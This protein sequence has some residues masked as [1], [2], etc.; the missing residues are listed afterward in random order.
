MEEE[1]VNRFIAVA[2]NFHQISRLHNCRRT[3]RITRQGLL[4]HCGLDEALDPP[5]YGDET[6]V[7]EFELLHD[8]LANS[9]FVYCFGCLEAAMI[10]ATK[11]LDLHFDPEV[12]ITE[13]AFTRHQGLT[14]VRKFLARNFKLEHVKDDQIGSWISDLSNIRNLLVHACGKV[15][16]TNLKHRAK[17][18]N[19]VDRAKRLELCKISIDEEV[20]VTED[21]LN[22]LFQF[23][24]G[25]LSEIC[26]IQVDELE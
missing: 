5:A 3:Y 15:E 9:V 17:M 4:K 10:E 12:S 22:F 26:R 7:K 1:S 24:E 23:S 21:G 13:R 2:S 11:A 19:T 8:P 14:K 6:W 16:N 25:Y 20:V 18:L